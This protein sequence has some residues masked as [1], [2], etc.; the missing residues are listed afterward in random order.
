[1]K[2]LLFLLVFSINSLA[3]Y[4]QQN[5][6]V[7]LQ[8]DSKQPFYIKL[9]EQLYSSSGSGYL[10]IPKLQNGT[11]NFAVGFPRAEWP[12]QLISVNI[13]NKDEGYLLKNF[14]EKGWGL[15]NMQSLD[16]IM[17]KSEGDKKSTTVVNTNDG[18]SDILAGVVNTPSLNE[19]AAI[20]KTSPVTIDAP[21]SIVKTEPV[22]K[23]I[24]STSVVSNSIRKLDA[25]IDNEGSTLI[26]IDNTG[27]LSDTIRIF[28]AKE[29]IASIAIKEEEMKV[30]ITNDSIVLANTEVK[31]ENTIIETPKESA[32][33]P[34]FID[35]EL[36]NPNSK[37]D[38][39]VITLNPPPVINETKL[40]MPV[41]NVPAD[42]EIKKE[43]SQSIISIPNSDCKQFATDEDF[44]K[45]RKKMAS[46]DKDEDMISAARKYFKSK[47]YSTEQVKNLSVLFLT[48]EG[49]YQFFDTAYPFVHDSSK[50]SSLQSQLT[51]SYYLNRFK[52][53][54]RQ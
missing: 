19:K 46:Y 36:P 39:A 4:S 48:D 49:K 50:F 17:A 43:N 29:P 54:V 28:I 7:Y 11:Y 13:N 44:L 53:M 40:E 37:Q 33:E 27:A 20:E 9:N 14:N 38:T 16:I 10:V 8:T 34:G 30:P 25:A 18:F 22:E 21:I 24:E 45:L 51:D 5:Y 12:Q 42:Q 35:I 6:F 32:K 41:V 23:A 15:F 31:S 26:Y 2:T 3:S 52:A 47:C 1:M